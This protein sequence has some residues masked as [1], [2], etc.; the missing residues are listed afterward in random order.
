M[1]KQGYYFEIHDLLTQF[2]AAFDDTVI[3]RYDKNRNEKASVEV[4]YVMAPKQRVM[5]DIVNKAQNI[6]LPVVA[7]DI[8][9]ITR[10]ESRVFHKLLPAYQPSTLSEAPLRSG[11][12]LMPVPVDI[13]VNMSIMTKYMS[14]MDQIISNFVP[15]NN[16][17]IVL[18]WEVPEDYGFE[19]VQEIRSAVDWSGSLS[20][21]NPTDLASSDKFRVVVDTSFTIRGWLFPEKKDTAAVIYKVTNNFINVDLQNRIYSP[22]EPTTVVESKTF[23]QY[24]YQTLSGYNDSVPTNYTETVTVSGIPEFTNIFY[25]L[26]GASKLTFDDITINKNKDNTFILYGKRFDFSNQFFLSSNVDN[27]FTNFQTITS[28]KSPTISGYKLDPQYYT[29][30][31]DN[32]V[33]MYF[34]TNTFNDS[35]SF[36]IISQTEAGW[37]T[38]Y[39]ASSSIITVE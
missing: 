29:V 8:T 1:N 38:S 32:I 28:A 2:I 22:L 34:P 5:Y 16:P 27:F 3:K 26:T 18:S 15:Y 9:S 20:Y 33:T 25:S 36:T 7:V 35:G 6:T 13:V 31:N 24:G 11:Q 19:Y 23:Q 10:D 39:Q 37:G 12:M 30:I 21:N 4:R 17:Y 14:D